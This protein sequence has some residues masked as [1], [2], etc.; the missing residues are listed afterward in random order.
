MTIPYRRVLLLL[1]GLLTLPTLQIGTLHADWSHVTDL[2]QPVTRLSPDPR[3]AK[4]AMKAHF[5]AQIAANEA[6]LKESS[7]D[8]HAYE[9]KVRLAVAQAKL[10]SLEGN[11]SAV[12]EALR[13]MER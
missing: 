2:D 9:S 12:T 10:A 5:E 11:P 1:I 8:T 3:R 13:G 6:F 7:K 4:L